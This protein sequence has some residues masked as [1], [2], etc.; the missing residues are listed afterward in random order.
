[1]K[2]TV[3]VRGDA[4]AN[5][6][7]KLTPLFEEA[8]RKALP[9]ISALIIDHVSIEADRKLST[10]A[11]QYKQAIQDPRAI[12]LTDKGLT[13]RLTTPLAAALELGAP[14]FDLKA[15]ML[16]HARRFS[17]EGKPF[18]DVSF[19]HAATEAAHNGLP[20]AV[21][22]EIDHAVRNQQ[23][24]A[25]VNG[26]SKA[27]AAVQTVRLDRTTPGRQFNRTLNINGKRVTTQVEHK[28]GIHDDLIRT[29]S[30]TATG[31]VHNEYTTIRRISANS[32]PTSW[33]HPGFRGVQILKTV[34]PRL[35]KDIE[36][37]IRDAC[38][39]VGLA[40]RFK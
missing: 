23:N 11:P 4:A 32:A 37:I 29:A 33:W 27:Q 2:F 22:R 39:S 15:R 34:M 16:L 3:K 25:F 9:K 19:K 17:M 30:T 14:S 38:T 31:R 18:I 36:A 26:A 20:A 5:L 13:I 35:Q 8:R 7:K 21:R 10:M 6:R 40:V 24:R 12:T 1:M 28:R